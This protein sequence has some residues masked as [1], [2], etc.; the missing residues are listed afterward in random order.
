MA[1]NTEHE[2]FIIVETSTD[3]PDVEVIEIIEAVHDPDDANHT[4]ELHEVIV[5][6]GGHAEV[7][8]EHVEHVDAD[9]VDAD[10]LDAGS[11]TIVEDASHPAADA[12]VSPEETA[13]AHAAEEAEA[14]DAAAAEAQYQADQAVAAGDYATASE[15]REVAENE[16]WEAGNNYTLHG[17][18]ADD[19]THAADHQQQASNY[20]Q[21]EAQYAAQG[22]Y[23]AAQTAA[24]HAV[25]ATGSADYYAS[26]AD[27][28]GQ[29]RAEE[30]QEGW[31]VHEQKQAESEVHTAEYFAGIGD[32]EHAAAYQG[33]AEEHLASADYHGE[34]GQHDAP[35]AV[36]DSSSDV[37]HDTSHDVQETA[38]DASHDAHSYDAHSYD[39]H[40]TDV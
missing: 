40:E 4:V 27:H 37:A 25:E 2:T 20:E 36:H 24:S 18:S 21:Q 6:E 19:L 13:A 16:A 31:A 10:H 5:V 26:G 38:Y 22:N 3:H 33:S 35:M 1:E 34:M 15:A 32:A 30:W 8:A 11:S 39:A 12:G 28:S 23:E 14:H 9:H 7:I 29:A 17:S